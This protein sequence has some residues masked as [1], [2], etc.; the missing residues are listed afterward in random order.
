MNIEIE[1][2]YSV[3]PELW[4]QVVPRNSVEVK[5]A[6]LYSDPQKTVRVRVMGLQGFITIKGKTESASRPEFEYEIPVAEAEELIKLFCFRIIEKTRHYV[7]HNGHLW[8]VDQFYGENEGLF[9]AEIELDSVDET[10]DLPVWIDKDIT[11]DK[12]YSNSMLAEKPYK[13]W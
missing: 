1:H 9:I 10:Y 4:Q 7:D 3:K 8:E 5:Q 6:Y 12:R 13:Y 2:K 11:A